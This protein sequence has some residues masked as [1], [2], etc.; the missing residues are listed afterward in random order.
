MPV[1]NVLPYRGNY[2]ADGGEKGRM[3][4]IRFP[5]ERKTDRFEEVYEEYY[6]AV[7]NYAYR[8]LLQP[9]N[10]EDVVSETF[11]KAMQSFQRYDAGKSSVLGWLCGIAHN[12]AVDFLRAQAVRSS[13]SLDELMERGD[14]P[15]DAR[16]E[17]SRSETE[18]ETWEILR[19]LRVEERELLTLRYWLGLSDREIGQ[20]L[21][22][23][24]GAVNAR[25]RRVLEKCRKL[26]KQT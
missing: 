10:T 13:L 2:R 15:E 16:N 21:G 6:G 4:W 26:A 1:R 23:T 11:L 25:F 19:Q 9:Q 8:I 17:W 3:K 14:F 18:W 20:R 22:V 12:C 24:E 7:Y 5:G